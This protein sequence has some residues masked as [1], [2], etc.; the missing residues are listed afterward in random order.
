MIKA[1]IVSPKQPSAVISSTCMVKYPAESQFT[2]TV[3]ELS[4]V[5]T[6]EP[7]K[8][9]RKVELAKPLSW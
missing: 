6:E 2:V 3:V 7:G 9:Q 1:S 5:I 4:L 8:D